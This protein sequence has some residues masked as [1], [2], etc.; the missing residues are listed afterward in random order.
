MFYSQP[1]AHRFGNAFNDEL[2]SGRWTESEIAVAWV[3]RSGTKHLE[4][5][6]RQFLSAGGI[7]R[8]TLGIDIENTSE[9]GLG[10][11]LAWESH[12]RIETSIHHNETDV[13]FHPKVYLLKNAADARLIIGSNN[14]T[15]AGLFRNTEA[16]LQV[17]AAASDPLIADV[18]A[19]LA[20]WRDVTNPLSKRL[21]A[22]LLTDLVRFGY[23]FPEKELRERRR[24]SN[25]KAAKRRKSSRR[26]FGSKI[27]SRPPVRGVK[28]LAANVPGTVMLMRVRRASD[29][30]R[31]TQVQIPIRVVNTQFFRGI[32]EI[33]SAHDGRAHPLVHASARGA[34]NT[35]KVE[36][37]EIEPLVDPV[38]RLERTANTILYQAF[39]STSALGAP[40]RQALQR[41]LLFEPPQTYQTI[42]DVNRATLWRFV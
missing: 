6:F 39:D 36:I 15:E 28:K 41:G 40:I 23:V 20:A 24:A 13:T 29:T 10:D 27:V 16:G 42:S 17:D 5:S 21:D 38:L 34:L 19:A 4:S 30:E 12:G 1:L 37:P 14:I 31:R 22:A 25:T 35:I 18:A 32:G 9:E 2:E 8:I 3:R 11:L 33:I 26:L 7:A